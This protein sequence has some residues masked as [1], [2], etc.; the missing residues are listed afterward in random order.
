[1][2]QV[3]E[4]ANVHERLVSPPAEV[5]KPLLSQLFNVEA[6]SMI[7][8]VSVVLDKSLAPQT[9]SMT[10]SLAPLD[11]NVMEAVEVALPLLEFVL[12]KVV[13]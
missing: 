9:P 11:D 3:V 13:A 6:L 7:T 12:V 1:M 10:K 2:D 8:E 5:A 4:A